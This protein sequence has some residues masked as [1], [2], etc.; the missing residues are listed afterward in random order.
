MGRLRKERSKQE[1]LDFGEQLVVSLK[2]NKYGTVAPRL[3]LRKKIENLISELKKVCPSKNQRDIDRIVEELNSFRYE[4]GDVWKV[5]VKSISQAPIDSQRTRSDLSPEASA[6]FDVMMQ[7]NTHKSA[8]SF[9][10]HLYKAL[11]TLGISKINYLYDIHDFLTKYKD[12]S[13]RHENTSLNSESEPAFNFELALDSIINL[14]KKRAINNF[15]DLRK[16]LYNRAKENNEL[17][18]FK[19]IK[20]YLER[21]DLNVDDIVKKERRNQ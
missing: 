21:L 17:E 7:L 4:L 20:Q 16:T 10:N 11:Q 5:W 8:T 1:W 3:Q 15:E 6:H 9:Y 13:N 12:H 14:F 19:Y 2:F 18:Q